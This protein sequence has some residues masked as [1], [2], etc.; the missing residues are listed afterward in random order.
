[1]INLHIFGASFVHELRDFGQDCQDAARMDK[2][3]R[4]DCLGTLRWTDERRIL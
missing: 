2:I 3:F 4:C 1:M